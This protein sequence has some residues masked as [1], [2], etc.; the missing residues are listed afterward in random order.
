MV[1]RGHGADFE[2]TT[3]KVVVE[4]DA[5]LT[6]P[7]DRYGR[8]EACPRRSQPPA[9]RP[10]II[11]PSVGMKL[12]VAYP[13]ALQTNGLA[14]GERLRNHVSKAQARLLFLFQWAMNP[15]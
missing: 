14:R 3:G 4:P 2:A 1:W 10:R 12:R 6:G 8:L 15:L 9:I 5:S 7:T 13:P 11:V